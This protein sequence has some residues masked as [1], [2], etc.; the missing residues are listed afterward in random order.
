LGTAPELMPMVI[1]RAD[2]D[3]LIGDKGP[4]DVP[5]LCIGCGYNLTGVVSARCPECGRPFSLDEI[6]RKAAELRAQLHELE[7]LNE[8]VMFGLVT[9]LCGLGVR[10]LAMLLTLMG[11]GWLAWLCRVAVIPCGM[12]GVFMGLSVLRV[13]RVPAW[14]RETL[15]KP[16]RYGIAS[17]SVLLG[18]LLLAATIAPW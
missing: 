5:P 8:W 11:V 2:L 4:S 1:E 7:G 9:A 6:N 18:L 14:A 12:A 13:R 10:V 3:R 15:A 17:A 16:P